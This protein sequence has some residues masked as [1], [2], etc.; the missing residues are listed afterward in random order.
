MDGGGALMNQGIHGIDMLCGLFGYPVKISGHAA[1]LHHDIEVEDTAAASLVF[2]CGALGVID[3][4]TAI[5]HAKPRR[6]ELCGTKASVTLEEDMIASAEG[7]D[8]VGNRESTVHGWMKPSDI[9]ADLHMAQY[10]NIAAAIRGED[11]LYY[12]SQ[13]AVHTVNVI[14]S[15]YRSSETG[16][17]V[18][19]D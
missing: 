7:I 14:L 16:K 18:C 10:M 13:D 17:T 3:A 15:I 4:G 11:E 8:L 12:T 19:L 5:K 9:S 1:T 2:P 6:L